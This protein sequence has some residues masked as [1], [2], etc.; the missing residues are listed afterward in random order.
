MSEADMH[1]EFAHLRA[2]LRSRAGVEVA[3]VAELAELEPSAEAQHVLVHSLRTV[4]HHLLREFIARVTI[5]ANGVLKTP[6]VHSEIVS[7]LSVTNNV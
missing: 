1:L 7:S 6:N 3:S 2:D 5:Q 4:Q